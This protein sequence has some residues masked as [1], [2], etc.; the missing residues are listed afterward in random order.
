MNFLLNFFFGGEI[1]RF[2]GVCF[3]FLL[4]WV[5]SKI[6]PARLTYS[7]KDIWD[8]KYDK[9][10]DYAMLTESTGQ[11]IIGFAVIGAIIL[12]LKVLF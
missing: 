8:M 1:I 3:I 2:I 11:K 9:G 6:N 7:F 12:I 5:L 4:G 10:D